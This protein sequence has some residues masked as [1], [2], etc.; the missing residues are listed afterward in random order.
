MKS[1][2]GER[3]SGEASRGPVTKKSAKPLCQHC[4]EDSYDMV[5]REVWKCYISYFCNTCGR[6]W[7]KP[8]E[9]A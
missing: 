5:E 1:F 9:T 7:T 2:S 6:S 4:G 3:G 8:K